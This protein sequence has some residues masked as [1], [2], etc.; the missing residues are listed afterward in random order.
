M[1]NIINRKET[2]KCNAFTKHK[3]KENKVKR[4]FQKVKD[5]IMAVTARSQEIIKKI[6][7]E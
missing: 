2:E 4:D 1:L 7:E 5:D 3:A 6:N